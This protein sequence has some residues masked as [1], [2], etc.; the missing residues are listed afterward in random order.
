MQKITQYELDGIRSCE[1]TKHIDDRG[2]FAEIL[3]G[4]WVECLGND[5]VLQVALS[6][7]EPG[8]IRAWHRHVRGQIDYLVVLNGTVK[9]AMYDDREG[10]LTKGEIAEITVSGDHLQIIR[11]PGYYWHG[12]KNMGNQSSTTLYFFNKLY[13]YNNPDEERRPLDDK[14]IINPKTRQPYEWNG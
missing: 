1:I 6:V 2:F 14:T 12:T 10:S 7:S 11:I 8:I 5:R 3:R 9:I 13:D 4:D